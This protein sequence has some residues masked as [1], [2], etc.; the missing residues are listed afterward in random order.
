MII[1][2]PGIP[3]GSVTAAKLANG[4]VTSA[5]IAAGAVI[6][7]S[8]AAGAVNN[9]AM[10]N[11]AVQSKNLSL[12]ASLQF[13]NADASFSTGSFTDAVVS[14]TGASGNWLVIAGCVLD[15]NTASATQYNVKLWDGTSNA[16]SAAGSLAAGEYKSVLLAA[17]I[18]APAAN[19]KLS[20][21]AALNSGVIRWNKSGGSRDT[22]INA[23]QLG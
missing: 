19:V 23:I 20:V 2:A 4:A 18:T 16:A 22:F 10:G 14:G 17:Y 12:Q 3:N 11:A 5:A 21:E 6:S 15:N 13:A 7:A 8:F 9:A 1:N